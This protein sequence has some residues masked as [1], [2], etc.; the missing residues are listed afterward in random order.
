MFVGGFDP[1]Q[2]IT[3]I[4]YFGL[5]IA[6]VASIVFVTE[7]QRKI[8]IS[9][10]K[11]VRGAKLYGGVDTYLPL[12]LNMAGVI[13][14]IFAGAFMNI[15]TIIGFLGNARTPWVAHTAKAIQTTFQQTNWQYGVL[16]FVLVFAFTFFSTFIYFKPND[17]AENLQ[18]NGG[19]IPG[20]RP[21]T[22]TEH[23]LNFLINRITLWGAI[24]LGFIAVLP[25]LVQPFTKDANLSIGGTSVLILVG[26][27]LEI[28]DQ[29]EAQL[30]IRSYEEF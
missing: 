15:P 21:G 2:L 6:I 30:I 16:L 29:M 26:V 12:K 7:A 24:F 19:F 28:K 14:I 10:A 25:F 20:I 27:A 11:K 17:V 4:V 22:Q 1:A 5:A 18:K 13:P 23:Y 3:A 8:P 9:Y